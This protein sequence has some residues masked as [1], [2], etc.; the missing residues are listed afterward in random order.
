MDPDG[1]TKR[2]LK[3]RIQ[4]FFILYFTFLDSEF[5]FGMVPILDG[6]SV[7]NKCL[8]QTRL[9]ISLHMCAPI[10]EL[11][12]NTPFGINLVRSV[13]RFTISGSFLH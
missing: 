12:T 1:K 4:H 5:I 7:V 2:A 10:T 9:P 8:K 11:S 6:D 3:D 13:S